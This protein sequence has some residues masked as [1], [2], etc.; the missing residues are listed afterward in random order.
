LP[1][2]P[3]NGRIRNQLLA[4]TIALS[5]NTRFDNGLG[6]VGLCRYI[7]TAEADPGPDGCRGSDDDELELSLITREISMEV[8]T[9]LGAN[10]TVADLLYLANCALAGDPVSSSLEAIAGAAGAI[11]EV[12]DECRFLV[13]C[14]NTPPGSTD[15]PTVERV[16]RDEGWTSSE[17]FRIGVAVPTT[18]GL[19]PS[20]PN[21]TR[22]S[23]RIAFGLPEQSQVRLSLYNIQGQRVKLLVDEVMEEGFKSV[24]MNFTNERFPSGIYFYRMEAKGLVS[25]QHFTQSQKMLLIQ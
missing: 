2:H 15:E 9:E 14:S 13:S 20:M 19:M 1:T 18:F 17:E 11:N 3:R 4:Q 22:S 21:P 8:L 5:L 16:K 23:A 25:G 24:E 12:F 7:V 10:N 6:A